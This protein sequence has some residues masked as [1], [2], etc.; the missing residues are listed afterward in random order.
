MNQVIFIK[1]AD[2]LM[3]VFDAIKTKYGERFFDEDF[4]DDEK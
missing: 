1:D 3:E 2:Y 4:W